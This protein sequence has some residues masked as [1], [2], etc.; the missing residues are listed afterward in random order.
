MNHEARACDLQTRRGDMPF[1][2]PIEAGPVRPGDRG[3]PEPGDQSSNDSPRP[4]VLQEPDRAV[5]FHHSPKLPQ[6]RHLLMVRKN[7]EQEGGYSGI[8]RVIGKT[9][10]RYIHLS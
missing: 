2:L 5:W 6:G 1:G 3:V 7:A 9:E 8:E 4:H 10:V